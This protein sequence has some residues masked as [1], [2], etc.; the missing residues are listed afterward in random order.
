MVMLVVL[1]FTITCCYVQSTHNSSL[2]VVKSLENIDKEKVS[3]WKNH[4]A[5]TKR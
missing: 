2:I 1:I 5:R 4:T 3:I